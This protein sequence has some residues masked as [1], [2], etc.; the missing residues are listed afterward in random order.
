MTAGSQFRAPESCKQQ[1]VEVLAEAQKLPPTTAS[2]KHWSCYQAV[3][4]AVRCKINEHKQA[5]LEKS[6]ETL[7]DM[8]E[9]ERHQWTADLCQHPQYMGPSCGNVPA[10]LRRTNLWLFGQRRLALPSEHL[11]CQ[12]WNLFGD[13]ACLYKSSITPEQLQNMKPARVKSFA[14]NGM[15]L[16]VLASV[17]AFTFGLPLSDAA[18][19]GE[20]TSLET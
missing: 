10:L 17:L 7:E 19:Q 20:V 16:Q 9:R 4:A 8:T 13:P 11:E 15:H 14:G 3:S 12:G 1:H 2:G 5:L 6:G 18:G